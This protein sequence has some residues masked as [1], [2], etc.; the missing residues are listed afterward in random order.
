[1]LEVAIDHGRTTAA[2]RTRMLAFAVRHGAAGYAARADTE[3][4]VLAADW[5]SGRGHRARITLPEHPR[6]PAA[7]G[8][9]ARQGAGSRRPGTRADRLPT[10]SGERMGD[11]WARAARIDAL[12]GLLPPTIWDLLRL[13]ASERL[14]RRARTLTDPG[15]I[16]D[17]DWECGLRP[18]LR[19]EWVST[20]LGLYRG[21]PVSARTHSQAGLDL[22]AAVPAEHHLRHRIKTELIAGRRRCRGRE[23]DAAID[24]GHRCRR[25][26]A[27]A[28][29]C[30]CG[31]DGEFLRPMP[32]T[33]LAT[34]PR[35]PATSAHE[36]LTR[37]GYHSADDPTSR[38]LGYRWERR[39]RPSAAH[40][41]QDQ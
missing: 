8:G 26:S 15:M 21:D 33:L 18:R 30:C 41:D 17:T 11:N 22:L 29:C 19:C 27:G 14:L 25:A 39:R 6:L 7:P 28:R 4:E 10:S 31:G 16:T 2:E 3:L 12:V 13:G 34:A 35:N 5:C 1:M 40:R 24:R 38:C 32:W 23:T 9:A 36:E 20:E 37:R